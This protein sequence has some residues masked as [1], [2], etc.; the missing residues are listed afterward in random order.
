MSSK[1]S[2]PIT[3]IHQPS[4][5][6]PQHH[7]L[8]SQNTRLSSTYCVPGTRHFLQNKA[9]A[10]ARGGPT[11][12]SAQPQ[13]LSPRLTCSRPGA[14]WRSCALGPQPSQ[15]QGPELSR[16]PVTRLRQTG[17]EECG[18]G[19]GH[20]L[21]KEQAIWQTQQTFCFW[22]NFITQWCL[23]METNRNTTRSHTAKPARGWLVQRGNIS[24]GAYYVL[25][26]GEDEEQAGCLP[27]ERQDT[28]KKRAAGASRGAA[29]TFR[30]VQKLSVSNEQGTI[31]HGQES[32][33]P[34]RC[35]K[36]VTPSCF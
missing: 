8:L 33:L 32:H 27:W 4:P 13:A 17:N 7:L 19:R 36:A 1:A 14:G 28:R 18:M 16:R 6:H 3:S 11:A 9:R 20:P 23:F 34:G 31:V 21:L 26:A 25:G 12:C 29:G 35:L 22:K 5:R 30:P 10:P 24:P 2:F 15:S